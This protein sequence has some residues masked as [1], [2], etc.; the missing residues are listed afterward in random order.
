MR[1]V[2]IVTISVAFSFA[3]FLSGEICA[4]VN[5]PVGIGL[6]VWDYSGN[7]S[8]FH[9]QTPKQVVKADLDGNGRQDLVVNFENGGIWCYYNG[10]FWS[11][12]HAMSPQRIIR[13]S[14]DGGN[15][16]DLVIDFGQGY[17]VWALYNNSSWYSIMAYYQT[18]A[19]VA[20]DIDGDGIDELI[21]DVVDLD[22]YHAASANL[23]L[24]RVKNG[25]WQQ[26]RSTPAYDLAAADIDGN[27]KKE[28]VADFGPQ[29]GIWIYENDVSWRQIHTQMSHGMTVADMDGDG[30]QEIIINF[31]RGYGIWCYRNNAYVQIHNQ[32][33]NCMSVGDLDGNGIPDLIV[34]FSPDRPRIWVYYNNSTW[35]NILQNRTALSLTTID[36]N[37]DG[38]DELLI[39]AGFDF[40]GM[41][42]NDV[43]QR[44]QA[45][46]QYIWKGNG[47]PSQSPDSTE[48][49]FTTCDAL[50][51]DVL[52]DVDR[53]TISMNYGVN[54]IA[55]HFRPSTSINKLLIYHAGHDQS[56]SDANVKPV[57][58]HFL[59][60]GYSVLA[61]AMPLCGM[62]NKPYPDHNSFAYLD[63]AEFSPISFFV[64]PVIESLN[65]IQ[66]HFSYSLIAM[67][68][69]SGGGWTTTLC[70]ALDTR[71]ARSYPVAGSLPT[72]L[73]QQGAIEVGDWE[74]TV[75]GL[76]STANYLE[77]HFMSASGVGRR[78]VQILNNYDNC[79]F[80]TTGREHKI[81]AY[82]DAVQ[83]ALV[84]SET[85]GKPFNIQIVPYRYHL[86]SIYM[87][88]LVIISNDLDGISGFTAVQNSANN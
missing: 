66:T 74:Q 27:G 20:G 22:P 32:P 52:C 62:N 1:N 76:Y 88:P 58:E 85:L 48:T 81:L 24:W 16:D 77:W 55:Y 26:I 59:A 53:Y 54:S 41:I 18:N 17:G 47:F 49:G 12:L 51:I 72:Y 15:Q 5:P 31:G 69:L 71:I 73:R 68:G 63:S 45:L 65:Y 6:D 40:S 11:Q 44:R 82:E 56:F 35:T 36:L 83:K 61:F 38:K 34:D 23:G 2:L 87:D 21:L 50:S 86:W 84:Q 10:S 37:G 57:I 7:I 4:Q 30:K 19:M 43:S 75:P 3:V 42:R 79:C 39:N 14:L 25:S 8:Q 80:S 46:V 70:A 64:E 67:A 78:Q 60:Q 29:N 33:A 28:I 9:A 13:A